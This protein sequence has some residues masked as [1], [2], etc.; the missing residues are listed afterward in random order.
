MAFDV[1]V[2][3]AASEAEQGKDAVGCAREALF[4]CLQNAFVILDHGT[5]SRLSCVPPWRICPTPAV[6]NGSW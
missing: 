5:R 4:A 2:E 6:I 3:V 1:G